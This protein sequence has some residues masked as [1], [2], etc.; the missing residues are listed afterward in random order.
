MKLLLA[1][2]YPRRTG[3]THRVTELF[4]EGVRDTGATV[5]DVDLTS[6]NIQPCTGCY[7]CWFNTPGQCIHQDDMN[8]LLEA[9]LAADVLVCATP[10]YFYSMTSCMKTFIERLFPLFSPGVEP[11]G[12]GYPRNHLRY[13]ERW[14]GKKLI[15]IVTGSL[16][17][18]EMYRPINDTFRLIADGLDL[19]LGGQLTRS[20]SYILD[21]T[22]SKPRT[23]KL[24]EQAFRAAGCEAGTTGRLSAKTT[25]EAALPLTADELH[26]VTYTN[27][28]WEH[29][30]RLGRDGV[31]LAAVQQRVAA[32]PHILMREMARS[33][34]PQ[35]AGDIHAIL[36]FDFPD[37]NI[38]YRL[39]IDRGRCELEEMET[40]TPHLRITCASDTWLKILSKQIA[41]RDALGNRQLALNGEKGLFA[42]LE[43]YFPPTAL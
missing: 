33:F 10:L 29:A 8:Q 23:M 9:V 25:R 12:A 1:R 18:P 3:F 2:G 16:R 4:L 21:F 22:L 5:T 34:D 41:V 20:E 42:K 32:D 37:R 43:R 11:S 6:A 17:H 40:T 27:L 30:S 24:V 35:A 28:Y 19:E 13:P 15:T 26:Y 38:H 39:T 7:D 14:R 31:D 36:Q